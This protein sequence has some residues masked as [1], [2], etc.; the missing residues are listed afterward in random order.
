M[1][2]A[3]VV[4]LVLTT[5][6]HAAGPSFT[7]LWHAFNDTQPQHYADV[8]HVARWV[9]QTATWRSY[10]PEQ[11]LAFLDLVDKSLTAPGRA[12]EWTASL[13]SDPYRQQRRDERGVWHSGL[14]MRPP[15]DCSDL[16]VLVTRRTADGLVCFPDSCGYVWFQ[17]F[18]DMRMRLAEM[19]RLVVFARRRRR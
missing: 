9:E 13:P 10:T 2:G 19:Q 17:V 1:R 16:N 6:A 14:C 8:R 7:E 18:C 12:Q 3:A 4:L 11:Q 15:L 5:V